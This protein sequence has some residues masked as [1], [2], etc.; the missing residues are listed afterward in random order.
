MAGELIGLDGIDT[1]RPE[2]EA[3]V[4][5]VPRCRSGFSGS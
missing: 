3:L 4:R 2:L 5:T 1:G